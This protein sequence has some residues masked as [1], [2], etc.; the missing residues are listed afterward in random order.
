MSDQLPSS[1]RERRVDFHSE[2]P[3]AKHDYRFRQRRDMRL[4]GSVWEESPRERELRLS[5]DRT[6]RKAKTTLVG[7]NPEP[8]TRPDNNYT[9][10]EYIK[11]IPD[12]VS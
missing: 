5:R 9:T 10:K 4:A 12:Q 3:F 2:A 8:T 1:R 6:R 11:Y 7:F